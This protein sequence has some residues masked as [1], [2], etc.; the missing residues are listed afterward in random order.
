MRPLR[1]VSRRLSERTVVETI[2]HDGPISRASLALRTG[3]SK[4]TVSEIVRDLENEGWVAETGRT[5]GPV[6][7]SAV[8]YEIVPA[9]AHVVAADV[10]GSKIKIGVLDLVGDFVAE[11]T[12]PTDRRGGSHVIDQICRMCLDAMQTSRLNP[13][14]AKLA[15]IGVPGVPEPT[16][17]KVSMAPNIPG[18]D[19]MD[20][21]ASLE[22][23]LGM[24]VVVSNDVNLAT[25]G[26]AWRGAGQGVSNLAYVALGT[27]IGSGLMIAGELVR[28]ANDAAGELGFLPFGANPLEPE[29]LRIGAFERVVASSGIR[30]RY[31]ERSGKIA[32]VV[33][34][35]DQA[36]DGEEAAQDVIRETGMLLAAGIASICAIVNPQKVVIGG[37]IGSRVELIEEVRAS[38]PRYFPSPVE[39]EGGS[40]G[41][42]ASLVGAAAVG[43]GL[44]HNALFGGDIGGDRITLPAAEPKAAP[45]PI[46]SSND[47]PRRVDN[48]EAS[49]VQP[50]D[51][52]LRGVKAPVS[53]RPR[54]QK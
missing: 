44:L 42:R 17:G 25:Q 47:T 16:S 5:A 6:G 8:T 33:E 14:N 43:L 29:S 53:A 27:G 22:R 26:E 2:L 38:L 41:S 12:E 13:G 32:E 11:A 24:R 7:R 31:H 37:S 15:V 40:L 30:S 18:L 34:I 35:F 52:T 45:D 23:G 10:G 46:H 48:R 19:A 4:Q 49:T 39:V 21:A 9:A 3:L 50:I 1:N 54:R 36:R 28:G 20:V 51:S